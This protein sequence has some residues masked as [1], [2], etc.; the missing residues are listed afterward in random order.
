MPEQTQN[1]KEVLEAYKSVEEL[2]NSVNYN[3]KKMDILEQISYWD[4][5]LRILKQALG[6]E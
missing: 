3:G 4:E 5:K 6:L 1:S 2:V